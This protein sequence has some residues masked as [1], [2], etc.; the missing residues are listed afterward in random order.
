MT[1]ISLIC[2]GL[3]KIREGSVLGSVYIVWVPKVGFE[4]VVRAILGGF[5]RGSGHS[6]FESVLRAILG[7]FRFGSFRFRGAIFGFRY[8]SD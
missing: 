7:G 3:F 4:S 5:R 8:R 2:A 1:V 6:V